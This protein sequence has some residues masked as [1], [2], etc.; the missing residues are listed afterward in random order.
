MLPYFLTSPDDT[1]DCEGDE[2]GDEEFLFSPK[3]CA[4]FFTHI[5]FTRDE[6]HSIS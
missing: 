2:D 3:P 5:T 4:S 1:D 6:L